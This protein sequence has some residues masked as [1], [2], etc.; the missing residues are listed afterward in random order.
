MKSLDNT[1][2]YYELLMKYDD[3]SKIK[4][5]EL[6]KGFRYEFYKPGDEKE[7]IM[8]HIESGEFTSIKEGQKYFHNFYGNFISE[9]NKRCI[10]IVDDST[11]EKVGTA[12]ISLLKEKEFGYEAAVD[13]FAIKKSYQGKKLAKP[14]ISKFIEIAKDLGHKQLILHTQTTTW[15]AAKLYLDYGFEILNK[16]EIN[17]WS[18]LK[19]LT[20][21]E[22]LSNYNTLKTEDIL[23]LRNLEIEKLLINMY[24]T[25]KF[26]YSVWYK[27]NLHNVYAYFNGNSYEYEY[28]IED[29]K[30]NLKEIQILKLSNSHKS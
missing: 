9:L 15:L 1:I 16:D 30:I 24:N 25:D 10:F 19:T 28:F 17:G 4:Q 21:H 5:Y 3:T 29:N 11:N 6:P 20:H 18:I 2:K 14:L 7:W 13:W 27:N 8:I 23:D 12:T 22:K 26:N